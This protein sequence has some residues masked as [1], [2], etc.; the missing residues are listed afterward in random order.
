MKS[1][2]DFFEKMTEKILKLALPTGNLLDVTKWNVSHIL[3]L[4]EIVDYSKQ[5]KEVPLTIIDAEI[6]AQ[7]LGPS[8][9]ARDLVPIHRRGGWLGV[10]DTGI[11]GRDL[12]EESG[13]KVEELCDLGCGYVDLAFVTTWDIWQRVQNFWSRAKTIRPKNKRV[14]NNLELFFMFASPESAVKIFCGTEY[15]CMAKK[16]ID[17]T[18][19]EEFLSEKELLE[20]LNLA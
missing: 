18:K 14:P 6:D 17:E 9:I 13:M 19:K 12:V 5:G 7:V 20:K 1:P 3:R 8:D 4:A 15:K 11:T 16:L 10:F 2:K